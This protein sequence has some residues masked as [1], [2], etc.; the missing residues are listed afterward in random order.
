[1]STVTLVDV[2]IKDVKTSVTSVNL[3]TVTLV[4]VEVTSV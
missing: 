2:G 1:M 3:P 4:G